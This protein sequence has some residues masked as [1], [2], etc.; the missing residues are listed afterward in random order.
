MLKEKLKRIEREVG[1]D[2][3][4]EDLE[5]HFVFGKTEEEIRSKSAKIEAEDPE[6]VKFIFEVIE[7]EDEKPEPVSDLER[8]SDEELEE[9]IK[10]A[11]KEITGDH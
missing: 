5:L 2:V 3:K 4:P 7:T 9:Q 11:E 6:T 8:L 1:T 10:K